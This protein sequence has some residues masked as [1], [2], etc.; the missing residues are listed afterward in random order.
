MAIPLTRSL[1]RGRWQP[2][3]GWLGFALAAWLLLFTLPVDLPVP[4]LDPSWQA[5]LNHAAAARWQFG[6][7]LVWTYG[8]MGYLHNDFYAAETFFAVLAFHALLAAFFVGILVWSSQQ[9][10][11]RERALFLGL[12][13]FLPMVSGDLI[14][15][16]L[17]TYAGGFLLCGEGRV[18]RRLGAL[19]LGFIAISALM[20][21]TFLFY[22][23]FML[24]CVAL[25]WASHRQWRRAVAPVLIAG[26][27]V[28]GVWGGLAGQR[29]VNLPAYLRGSL[30]IADAYQRA[31]SLRPTV[32]LTAAAGLV[33]LVVLV[34]LG[35]LC[36]KRHPPRGWA[37][38]L[39][40]AGGLFLAWKQG[41]VR[42]DLGHTATFLCFAILLGTAAPILFP[43]R[44]APWSGQAT[45]MVVLPSLMVWG[46][47]AP[48][49]LVE[50][51]VRKLRW[52]MAPRTMLARVE[53]AAR[54][55]EE[56]WALP[57]IRA[58][59][60][61]EP[62]DVFGWEQ[63]IALLNHLNYRPAP[64]FQ[65]YPATTPYLAGLNV[66]FYRSERAPAFVLFKLQTIDGRFPTLDNGLVL[67]EL[68]RGYRHVLV[69]QDWLL[70]GR[71]A[72]PP[73]NSPPVLI[74]SGDAAA[75][76]RLPL[77]AGVVW[78]ELEVE[79]TSLCRL[80][81]FLFQQP[82][83]YLEVFPR[84]EGTPVQYRLILST[85]RAGFLLSPLVANRE[86][87]DHLLSG[88]TGAGKTPDLEAIRVKPTN[89]FRWLMK[90]RVGYRFYRL[91]GSM[92]P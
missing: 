55:S 39:L 9:R 3:L 40:A 43:G 60:G 76:E 84:G 24:A 68:L 1:P 78:C 20:K 82:P 56:S 85:A 32:E 28:A 64:V 44:S 12:N 72:D 8:P 7:D 14:Y 4:E 61:Q 10:P 80:V 65:A 62:V 46:L 58:T 42:A 88:D 34:W 66:T 5:V 91:P 26:L 90:P 41:F 49:F 35:V 18:D 25:H 67:R 74:R 53:A 50:Q 70:L 71:R 75:G 21:S 92:E 23:V 77:P 27:A 63:A 22:A 36:S 86:D 31:M 79:E 19:A 48:G 83:L 87:F 47:A 73:P 59:V 81:R 13:V 37:R 17:I 6:A 38:L 69:E 11:R 89:T 16:M 29:F 45:A 33:F 2:V 57:R 51:N 52:L 15:L 54:E 30:E